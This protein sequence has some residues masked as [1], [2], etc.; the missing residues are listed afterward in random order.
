[1]IEDPKID[2][3]KIGDQLYRLYKYHDYQCNTTKAR[4]LR[5]AINLIEDV[6]GIYFHFKW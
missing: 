6:H 3:D 1:M 5:K 2:L 4:K